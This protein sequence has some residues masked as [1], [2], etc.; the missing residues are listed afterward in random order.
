MIIFGNGNYNSIY[1][2]STFTV[3]C[4]INR[5]IM[6]VFDCAFFMTIILEKES[7]LKLREQLVYACTF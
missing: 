2:F 4:I 5:K 7:H 1:I 6:R 3:R